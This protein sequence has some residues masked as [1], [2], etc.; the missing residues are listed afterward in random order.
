MK[1]RVSFW[2]LI[3]ALVASQSGS[4][5][6][7][8]NECPPP[9]PDP[10]QCHE[11]PAV[12][13]GHPCCPSQEKAD[14]DCRSERD[15]EAVKVRA[16]GTESKVERAR[17]PIESPNVTILES[18][19]ACSAAPAFERRPGKSDGTPELYLLLESFLI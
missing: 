4:A 7:G 8:C 14:S 10:L 12:K 13:T 6:A 18:Q 1:S 3:F 11:A 5:L 19:R 2:L 9:R 16:V 17:S 15:V